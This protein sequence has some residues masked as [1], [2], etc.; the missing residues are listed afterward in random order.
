MTVRELAEKLSLTTIN[1]SEGER[2]FSGAYIGDLLSWV[3][4]RA[5]Q[6][7]V[8]ITIMSNINIVAVA[9]L[10][11]VACI[12]LAEGVTLEENVRLTAEQKGVNIFTSE[13]TAYELAAA[14]ASFEA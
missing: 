8:W 7:Q 9:S 4:G 6:D 14:L 12:I 3:M 13:K 10:T 2:E 11:D 5:G 1:L